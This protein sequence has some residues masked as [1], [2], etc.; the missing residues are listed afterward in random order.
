MFLT[1]EDVRRLTGKTRYTAQ[2]RALTLLGIRFTV[3]A[4]GEPLVRQEALDGSPAKS[5]NTPRWHLIN[6]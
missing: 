5:R 6:A 1:T 4:T 2:R 3:A